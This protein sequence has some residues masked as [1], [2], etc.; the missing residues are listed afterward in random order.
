MY[1]ASVRVWPVEL[2]L[3][4]LSEPDRSTRF[5]LDLMRVPSAAP[6]DDPGAG[7]HS[8]MTVKMQCDRDDDWF[9]SVSPMA[10][11]VSP[12]KSKLRASSSLVAGWILKLRKWRLPSSSSNMVTLG[13][14][15]DA[16]SPPRLLSSKSYP[17]SLYSSR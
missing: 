2:V 3:C 13:T 4:T 5:N 9:I 16:A 15:E 14:A 11:L 10:R 17:L 6:V 1:L 8:I 7:R 12:R